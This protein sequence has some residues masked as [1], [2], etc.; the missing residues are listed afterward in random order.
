ML[1]NKTDNLQFSPGF[2]LHYN[3]EWLLILIFPMNSKNAH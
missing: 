1:I 3:V 2:Q